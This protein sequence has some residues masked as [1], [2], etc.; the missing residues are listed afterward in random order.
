MSPEKGGMSKEDP[1]KSILHPLSIC[2][3]LDHPGNKLEMGQKGQHGRL[4]LIAVH[5]CVDTK[6]TN[7][8]GA[9]KNNLAPDG[10]EFREF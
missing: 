3:C 7:K 10:T 1:S 5:F 8:T 4:K 6:S 2:E 9:M